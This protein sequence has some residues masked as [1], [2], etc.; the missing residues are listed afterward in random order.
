MRGFSSNWRDFLDYIL[1]ITKEIWENRGIG[2]KIRVYYGKDVIVRMP[3]A[4]RRGWKT[5][6]PLR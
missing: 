3:G 5:L 6:W 2:S 4:Y 1:G